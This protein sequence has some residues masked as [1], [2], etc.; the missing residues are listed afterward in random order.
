M[1]AILEKGKTMKRLLLLLL[2]AFFPVL[3]AG[4]AAAQIDSTARTVV[5]EE[6]SSA[7]LIFEDRTSFDLADYLGKVLVLELA[8]VGC[9][10]SEE[11]YRALIDLREEYPDNVEFVRIDYGQSLSGTRAYYKKYPPNFHVIGDPSGKIGKSFVSQSFP[12]LYLFGKWG[13]MRYMGGFDPAR[14][15]SMANRLSAEKKENK[16]NF[17]LDRVLDKGDALPCFT[18]KDF[19]GKSVSLTEYC[20]KAKAFVLV[21]AGTSCPISRIAVQNL[22]EF[23]R[24][25]DYRG[26][27]VLVVN[28]GEEAKA[29]KSVYEPMNLPFPVLVDA[30]EK[31]AKV[32]KIGSVPTIFVAGKTGK[33][34]CRSLWNFEAVKQEVDIL[35]GKIKPGHRK[36]IKA[37]GSG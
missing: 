26:L 9:P 16:K 30:K 25:K 22:A 12:T 7:P 1:L 27:S 24:R 29:V 18:I 2:V 13:K 14:F 20:G 37:Q 5:E 8:T 34:E 10:L 31:L 28:I 4:E 21:I 23:S 6:E 3:A 33:V 36:E 32:L 11:I 15:R 35:L 19:D 17:F